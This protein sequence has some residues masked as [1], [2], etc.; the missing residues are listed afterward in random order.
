MAKSTKIAVVFPPCWQSGP[1]ALV[2]AETGPP[3]QRR[4]PAVLRQHR[5]HGSGR[6]VQ[7]RRPRRATPGRRRRRGQ[8]WAVDRRTRHL[9]PGGQRGPAPRGIAGGAS[10]AGG[11]RGRVAARGDG[12]PRR[13]RPRKPPRFLAELKAGSHHQEIDSARGETPRR[14]WRRT[15]WRPNWRNLAGYSIRR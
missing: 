8:A 2:W 5:G 11:V 15:A 14:W 12:S 1:W 6:R 3:E 7:D 4:C 9:G 13:R 10:I